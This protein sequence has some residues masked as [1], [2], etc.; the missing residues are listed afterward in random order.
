MDLALARRIELR[1]SKTARSLNTDRY[2][3]LC[4]QCRQAKEMILGEEVASKKI[5]LMGEGSRLIAG[6][7]T[8][9]LDQ[10][11]VEHTVLEGFFPIVDPEGEEKNTSK[12]DRRVRTTLRAGTCRNASSGPVFRQAS[13]RCEKHIE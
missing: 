1:F 12:G 13:E 8:A 2:K 11:E 4:H 9:E 5:I 6:T 10:E 3:A 7:L